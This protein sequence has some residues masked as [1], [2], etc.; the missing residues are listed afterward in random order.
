MLTGKRLS[1]SVEFLSLSRNKIIDFPYW[2]CIL[3]VRTAL[4]EAVTSNIC[5]IHILNNNERSIKRQK[6]KTASATER[7]QYLDT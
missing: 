6:A 3:H 1:V 4:K 7:N 5:G 2:D